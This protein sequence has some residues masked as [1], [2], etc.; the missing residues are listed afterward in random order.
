MDQLA[1]L[2]DLK[3]YG[4]DYEGFEELAKRL[5]ESVSSAVRSAAGCPISL[6]TWTATIPSERS[7]KLDLPCRAVR[8]VTSVLVDG[9]PVDDWTLLGSSL[10]RP[11]PW[12]PA[13]GI[14][15]TVTITMEAGWDPIPEDII[16][17]VCAYTAAGLNQQRDGGPG[18]HRGVSYERI[19]DA[20]VGYLSGDAETVD[21]T[22]L[23]EAT[24]RSLRSRFGLPGI[25]IGVFR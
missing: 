1:S 23:T 24:R 22:E 14:P 8:K 15:R 12:G 16:R 3:A 4:V 5:L 2:D 13:R 10:Y 17:M 9:D 6:G 19:D 18:S 20:Q 21:A 25:S 11:E 7:R